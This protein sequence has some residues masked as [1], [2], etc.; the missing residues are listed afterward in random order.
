MI[1]L[2]NKA[3]SSLRSFKFVKDIINGRNRDFKM[4]GNKRIVLIEG[5]IAN[6]ANKASGAI[7]NDTR[8]RIKD[9]MID[10]F[11]LIA[12]HF[13]SR[14]MANGA[15]MFF[16]IQFDINTERAGIMIDADNFN[17]GMI[18]SES[19]KKILKLQ[20]RSRKV[21]IRHKSHQP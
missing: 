15:E 17:I 4:I 5:F 12:F 14:R 7:M 13:G 20:R 8:N 2:S 10:L 11:H 19:S 21:K 3:E 16:D 1:F 9:G 6:R 18:K